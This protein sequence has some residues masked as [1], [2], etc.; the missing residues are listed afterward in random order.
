MAI[1]KA[2]Y[3]HLQQFLLLYRLVSIKLRV[4]IAGSRTFFIDFTTVLCDVCES[5]NHVSV[6]WPIHSAPK[7]AG[8][9]FGYAHEELTFIEVP[10]SIS[11]RPKSDNDQM[12]RIPVSGGTLN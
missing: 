2:H 9:M 7:P 12:G 1:I 8:S 3:T 11:F 4:F 5:A 6:D 10:H